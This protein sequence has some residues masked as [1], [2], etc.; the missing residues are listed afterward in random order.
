MLTFTALSGSAKSTTT[1]P[2]C[3][4]LQVDDV[5]ILLDCGSPDWCPEASSSAVKTEDLTANAATWD[6]YCDKL[7][8]CVFGRYVHNTVIHNDNAIGLHQL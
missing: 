3:Y 1:S 7:Q 2:L 4:L 8:E 5:R 6:Q